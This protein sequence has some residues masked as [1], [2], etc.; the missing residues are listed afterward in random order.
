MC[1]KGKFEVWSNSSQ[2]YIME[3]LLTKAIVS[4]Y[5]LASRDT[6][7]MIH[8]LKSLLAGCLNVVKAILQQSYMFAM[9]LT[10]MMLN[11]IWM[12]QNPNEMLP[13]ISMEGAVLHTPTSLQTRLLYTGLWSFNLTHC[14][15]KI[16]VISCLNPWSHTVML[17]LSR[18]S[19][20]HMHQQNWPILV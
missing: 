11:F 2:C 17:D 5:C 9:T 13:V 20:A 3:W 6:E 8:Y 18:W 16:G 14:Y 7:L 1:F 19:D 15:G 10:V 12:G 4:S